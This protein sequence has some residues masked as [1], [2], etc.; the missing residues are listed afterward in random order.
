M[1]RAA[2]CGSPGRVPP[3]PR[4][5]GRH[6]ALDP[7][8][9]DPRDPAPEMDLV[10][11]LELPRLR[12]EAQ[13]LRVRADPIVGH[14][15]LAHGASAPHGTALQPSRAGEA[16]ARRGMVAEKSSELNLTGHRSNTPSSLKRVLAQG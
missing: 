12:R 8:A 9:A 15:P 1:S 7:G 6:P 2:H 5:E 11:A 3:W 16:G 4:V 10:G 14:V 13:G